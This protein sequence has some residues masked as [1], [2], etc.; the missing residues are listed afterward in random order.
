MS[1]TELEAYQL[2]VWVGWWLCLSAL[3]AVIVIL[4]GGDKDDDG[5]RG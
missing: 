4:L 5:E 2:G 3:L 1:P